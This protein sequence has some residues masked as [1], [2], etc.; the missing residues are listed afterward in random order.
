VVESRDT[1]FRKLPT[2]S[3][4]TFDS[5]LQTKVPPSH[6]AFVALLRE[7]DALSRRVSSLLEHVNGTLGQ[8]YPESPQYFNAD[9]PPSPTAT[10]SSA[11]CP[12]WLYRFD[13]AESE[14]AACSRWLCLSALQ[15]SCT[16]LVAIVPRGW[17]A[18][19]ASVPASKDSA[20]HVIVECSL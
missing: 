9:A 20:L 7:D 5:V 11:E 14:Y 18:C 16:L 15:L 3:S 13:M 2:L 6:L 12:Y 8:L 1:I 4:K 17:S 19:T 10:G